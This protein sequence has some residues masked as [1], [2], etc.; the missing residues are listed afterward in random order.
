MLTMRKASTII[1]VPRKSKHAAGPNACD[2]RKGA[3]V[4]AVTGKSC[5]A[6]AQLQSLYRGAI[7]AMWVATGAL[8]RKT[9]PAVICRSRVS[10]FINVL[11]CLDL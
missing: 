11:E 9:A 7:D 10:L 5:I 1:R 3:N 4:R 8:L 2:C 6:V